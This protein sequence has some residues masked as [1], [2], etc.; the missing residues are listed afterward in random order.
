[1]KAYYEENINDRGAYNA[2]MALA[3][4]YPNVIPIFGGA[5][6]VEG[7]INKL[8]SC[9]PHVVHDAKF[10][11]WHEGVVGAIRTFCHLCFV[12]PALVECCIGMSFKELVEV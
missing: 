9:I 4:K 6:W 12:D 8:I 5:L 3:D 7:D 2:I 11:N 1:M 10:F